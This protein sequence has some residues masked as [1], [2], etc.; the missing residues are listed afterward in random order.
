MTARPAFAT[1]TAQ[2]ASWAHQ[3]RL[4]DVPSDV[5]SL[6]KLATADNVGCMLAGAHTDLAEVT[7]SALLE[8]PAGTGST[9]AG[10]SA[11]APA[12]LAAFLNA[13]AAN[14]LDYDDAF[15]RG[16][17]GIGH[18]GSTVIPTALAMAERCG[19]GGKDVLAAVIAGYEVANRVIEAIQPSP[20]RHAAVWGVAVHQGFGAAIVAARLAG[21]NELTT[22]DAI[23]LAGAFATVPAARKWN[24]D[25][26]PLVWIKDM[27][28]PPA[29]AGIRSVLLAQSGYVGS[30]DILDGPH[31]FWLMA[32]SD[33]FESNRL[34]DGLGAEWTIRDLALKPY[35]ACR[36]VHTSLEAAEHLMTEHVLVPDDIREITVGSFQDLVKHFAVQEPATMVDAEFSVPY[37]LAALLHNIPRGPAWYGEE[38]LRDPHILATA[39]KVRLI[40]DG[41]AQAHHFR[42]QRQTMAAVTITRRDGSSVFRRV[43]VARGAIQGPDSQERARRKF[44]ELAGGSIGRPRAEELWNVLMEIEVVHDVGAIIRSFAVSPGDEGRV[45]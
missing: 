23:G 14:A 21:L 24:W 39:R 25:N 28:A 43:A 31:G 33:Q 40:V 30:R 26:R 8:Q 3:L 44:M 16:G 41:E 4:E 5:V 11:R 18:P 34:T 13:V 29:E 2:L 12:A 17:K 19:S 1:K 6:A 9:V 42:P 22:L 20:E 45:G 27:V 37:P 35:P 36:W 7:R 15:E 32:S 38:A 10:T